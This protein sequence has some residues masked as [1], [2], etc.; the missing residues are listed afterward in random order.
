MGV[1]YT[2]GPIVYQTAIAS[3]NR[4]VFVAGIDAI[5]SKVAVARVGVTGGWKYTFQSPEGLQVKLWVQDL[6]DADEFNAYVRFTPTSPD[7]TQTGL[8][9]SMLVGAGYTYEAWANRCSFFL[10]PAGSVPTRQNVGFSIGIPAL[11]SSNSGPCTA[12]G[13]SVSVTQLWWSANAAGGIV[14]ASDFRQGRTQTG[15]YSLM[16]NGA[17]YT[18]SDGNDALTLSLV[19]LCTAIN[20]DGYLSPPSTYKYGGGGTGTDGLRI[21]ALLAQSSQIY[22]QLWD[23]HFYTIPVTLDTIQSLADTD[24]DGNPLSTSWVAWNNSIPSSP[25][26]GAGTVLGTLMLLTGPPVTS[27]L[28]NVAF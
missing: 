8:I 6:G 15:L 25:T 17:L 13:S 28:S 27:S 2:N 24:S 10:A 22:G 20:V 9:Q 5:L 12:G 3:T 14:G 11:A 16:Y 21:D 1:R 4:T 19:T 26:H 23:A 7:E 18:A